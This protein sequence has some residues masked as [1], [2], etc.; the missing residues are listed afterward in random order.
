MCNNVI[1]AFL[2]YF[3]KWSFLGYVYILYSQ[4]DGDAMF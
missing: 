2:V 4:E 1:L 3:F